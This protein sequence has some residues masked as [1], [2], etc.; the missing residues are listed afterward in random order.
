MIRA[1]PDRDFYFYSYEEA[2]SRLGLKLIMLMAGK[3]LS[4]EH[5]QGEYLRY[6]K[7]RR[8]TPQ[9]EP[10]IEQAIAELESWLAGGRLFLIDKRLTGEDLAA[11]IGHIA[12]RGQTGAVFVDY[13]QKIPLQRQISPRYLEIKEVSGLL[14]EQAVAQNIPIILGAQ[15]GRGSGSG[16]ENKVKLDNLREAGDIEQ[17]ASLVLGLFNDS[18]DKMEEQ[19]IQ[20]KSAAVDLELSI[21]KHRAG[22]AGRSCMLSFERPSLRIMEKA[23]PEGKSLY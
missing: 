12:G 14:L 6:I 11:T 22:I 4:Q 2:K 19:G 17:D 7:E 23:K 9:A 18:Q 13:I 15:F 1:Y 5:N 20:D 10:A 21:L 3:F 16:K 8:G